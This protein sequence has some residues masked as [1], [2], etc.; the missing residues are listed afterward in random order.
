[1]QY[2]IPY[3]RSGLIASL[4]IA[5]LSSVLIGQHSMLVPRINEFL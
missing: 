2:M 5:H 4:V 3:Y 1:M